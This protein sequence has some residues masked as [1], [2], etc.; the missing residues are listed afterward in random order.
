MSRYVLSVL[1]LGILVSFPSA[2]GQ[3]ARPLLDLTADGAVARG[4]ATPTIIDTHSFQPQID[5]TTP[6]TGPVD[7]VR[8]HL[9]PH[10]RAKTRYIQEPNGLPVGKTL[11]LDRAFGNAHFPGIQQTPWTPPDP[12]IAVGPNHIVETV[13]MSL[14]FFDKDG[15]MTFSQ[16]LDSTGDPGFFEELGAG[17]FTFDPKCFYDPYTGRFIVLALEVYS[18]IGE[19]WITIA[20]SDDSDPNGIWY[21]YRTW[22]VVNVSGSTYWVDYPGLG[23][24]QDAWYVTGNLFKLAGGGS[25]WGGVIFRI[26]DKSSM[27]SGG[28]TVWSDMR[29]SDAGSVQAGQC[30]GSPPAGMFV[31]DWGNT[32]IRLLAITNPL[33]APSFTTATVNVPYLDYPWGIDAPNLGGDGIDVLDGRIINVYWRD[34]ELLTGHGIAV[35]SRAIARWY[36]VDTGNWPVSGSPTLV[37][38]GNIDISGVHTWFPALCMNADGDIGLVAARSSSSEYAGVV[39]TGRKPGDPLGTMGTPRTVKVGDGSY[40][41][42]RW[43]DYFD[44]TVDP[45]NDRTFWAV[46]EYARGDGG[47][48]TYITSFLVSPPAGDANCD[49]VVN[50]ADIGAFVMALTDPAAYAATYPLCDTLTADI[51][52]NGVVN[53]ADVPAFVDLLLD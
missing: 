50:N 8:N 36:H 34:G 25:G 39:I 12:T 26:F 13:N 22:S 27:L 18:D 31:E 14:A 42:Y 17:D 45:T 38:S 11:E 23:F 1:L 49:G 2:W 19:S 46:G 20:V 21:K 33:T 32:Q 4:T 7:Q 52:G 9:P 6:W 5:G 48:G 51:D 43:G 30:L 29:R 15:T 16:R 28:A 3:E 37:Q 47:W 53:N 41:N 40:F 35:G 10:K 24:D 44:V